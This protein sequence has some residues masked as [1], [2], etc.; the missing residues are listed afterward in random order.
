MPQSRKRGGK[1]AHNKR[2]KARNQKL[3][4]DRKKMNKLYSEMMEQK[5]K[6]FTDKFSGLTENEELNAENITDVVVDDINVTH[7]EETPAE[8]QISELEK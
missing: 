6:E 2:V 1:K 8:N 3:E 4:L 5:L 7:K